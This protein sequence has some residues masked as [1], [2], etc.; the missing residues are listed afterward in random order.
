MKNVPFLGVNAV[1]L[2]K[3][4]SEFGNQ[5]WCVVEKMSSITTLC[6]FQCGVAESVPSNLAL[7]GCLSS[8][9]C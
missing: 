7:V 8:S 6:W 5:L 9:L 3:S 4:K 2:L 1:D